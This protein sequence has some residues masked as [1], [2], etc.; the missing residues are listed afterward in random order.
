MKT[1]NK[2]TMFIWG[3][4]ILC[5]W[6]III[7]IAYKQR[8]TVYIE[9]DKN[10]KSVANAYISNNKIKLKFNESS[11]IYIKDLIEEEYIEKDEVYVK[12]CVDSIIVHKGIFGLEYKL[13]EE[14]DAVKEL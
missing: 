13:N 7:F 5:L 10:L 8:D 1:M 2:V 3:L 12:Y 4:L 14:C 9:L 11:Q 6:T